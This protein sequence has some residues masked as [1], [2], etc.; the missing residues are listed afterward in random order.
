MV[1]AQ[2]I[3]LRSMLFAWLALGLTALNAHADPLAIVASMKGQVEVIPASGGT[4]QRATFGRPLERGDKVQVGG[5]GAATVVFNDGN[6][7][8]LSSGSAITIGGR[9]TGKP[10]VGPGS[11]L[12]DEVFT[13]VS[14]YVTGGSRQKGLVALSA[15]RS[16]TDEGGILISP[17][18]SDVMSNRPRFR[19]RAVTG[20]TRYK[21]SLSGD[22]GD[23][24]ET[25][26]SD[27]H[28]V[29]P[30]NVDPL[31]GDADYVW[32]IVAFGDKGKV[33]E[34][35]TFFHVLDDERRDV[36]ATH[37][38]HIGQSTG[39]DE[40]AA[41]HFLAGSY[42]FSRG[43]Y[44]DAAE[45]FEALSLISPESPAPHEALGN[46]YKAVGLMDLAAAEFERALTLTRER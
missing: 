9:M 18:D 22:D 13:Q 7:I 2:R 36:V 31:M 39:G 1:R 30:G 41:T 11:S 12:P 27:T 37:I 24:W 23:L 26:S 46:V 32:R 44:G 16:G 21:L 28:A 42:L 8:E 15:M 34:E 38:E 3:A 35:E 10:K 14:R 45:H 19:W 40:T 5:E 29:L 33:R 25:E 6:V 17:R 20:A 43:M 4:A